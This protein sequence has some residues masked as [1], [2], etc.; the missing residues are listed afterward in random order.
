MF[1]QDKEF[2]EYESWKFPSWD[3]PAVYPNGYDDPEIQ[4]LRRTMSPSAFM[5]EIGADFSSFVGKIYPD[6]DVSKHVKNVEFRPELPN[7]MAIDWGYTNPSAWIEFQVTPDDRIRV[8]REHYEPYK[9]L[10]E[11]IHDIKNREQ[12]DGYHLDLAFGDSADPGSAD[13]VSLNL[14]GCWALPEAKVN[15]REGIDLVSSFLQ[16]RETGR[17]LDEFGT[18]EILPAF[19]VD[20]S[21]VNTIDEFNN[22]RAPGSVH[23]RN[24]PEMGNKAKDHAMDAIRYGLMHLFRL[25][26]TSHLSDVYNPTQAGASGAITLTSPSDSGLVLA[27]SGDAGYFTMGEQF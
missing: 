13:V 14:I 6:W 4:L 7:Y 23:G 24:V 19:S 20:F 15:W 16:D 10:P 8:W 25:G 2:P 3:N 9:T 1:G 26:A 11:H 18:P 12:P 27:P 21:C 17:E 5:Q 22:Y